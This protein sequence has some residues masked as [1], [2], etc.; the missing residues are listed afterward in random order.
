MLLYLLLQLTELPFPMVA[1]SS[2]KLDACPSASATIDLHEVIP[3]SNFC[4]FRRLP[5][6]SL[7]S[8]LVKV[9]ENKGL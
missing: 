3:S 9:C 4:S 6:S 1:Q 5:L 7:E 8:T 2:P